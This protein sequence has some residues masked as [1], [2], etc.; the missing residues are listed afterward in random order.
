MTAIIIILIAAVQSFKVDWLFAGRAFQ[1]EEADHPGRV[2][3]DGGTE[4][5]SPCGEA[6][7]LALGNSAK[8]LCPC[9]GAA[10]S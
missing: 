7:L 3:A 5:A 1:S 6:A 2:Q 4:V 8:F 10:G 9:V